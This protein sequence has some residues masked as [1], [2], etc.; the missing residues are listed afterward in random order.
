LARCFAGAHCSGSWEP[1]IRARNKCAGDGLVG[2]ARMGWHLQRE[3]KRV[4]GSRVG[5][6][7]PSAGLSTPTLPQ[8]SRKRI[9]PNKNSLHVGEASANMCCCM[10]HESPGKVCFQ[11]FMIKASYSA[12]MCPNG[13]QPKNGKRGRADPQVLFP[14][15][16]KGA[17]VATLGS[18]PG[19]PQ[20]AVRKLPSQQSGCIRLG[21]GCP[22][23]GLACSA[24]DSTRE[25]DAKVQ[26]GHCCAVDTC[27]THGGREIRKRHPCN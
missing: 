23:H 10:I 4:L 6:P 2:M 19:S 8:R 16:W 18:H 25:A 14:A 17:A 1:P 20:M 13:K 27:S 22:C 12:R 5:L 24:S 15:A 3:G 7:V 26:K 11:C 21:R 9:S